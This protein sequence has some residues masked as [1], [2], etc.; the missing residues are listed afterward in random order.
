MADFLDVAKD[1]WGNVT[2][3]MPPSQEEDLAKAMRR[4]DLSG[5][6]LYAALLVLQ[7]RLAALESICLTASIPS[8]KVSGARS[9]PTSL[10]RRTRPDRLPFGCR[11]HP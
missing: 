5:L 4:A 11:L 10:K 7:T 3:R 6:P 1:Q 9:Q 8:A 2:L